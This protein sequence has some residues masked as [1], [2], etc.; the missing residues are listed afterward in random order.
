MQGK[1]LR[2]IGPWSQ[3]QEG[4][5]LGFGKAGLYIVNKSED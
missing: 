1:I 3:A 2:Q 5:L 4:P